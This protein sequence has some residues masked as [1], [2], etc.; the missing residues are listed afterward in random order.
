MKN[1]KILHTDDDK[2]TIVLQSTI[3]REILDKGKRYGIACLLEDMEVSSC[4][5]NLETFELHLRFLHKNE[6][7]KQ[8]IAVSKKLCEYGGFS[9]SFICNCCKKP[10]LKL[11]KLQDS[12]KFLCREG[13][14]QLEKSK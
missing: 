5:L 3:V 4:I 7:V 9:Y 6:S 11:F 12:D 1:I 2:T 8:E 14:K 13:L 10:R